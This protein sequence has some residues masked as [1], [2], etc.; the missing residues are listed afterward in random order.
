MARIKTDRFQRAVDKLMKEVEVAVEDAKGDFP[1][2]GEDDLFYEMAKAM[3]L[4]SEASEAVKNEVRR[5][6]GIGGF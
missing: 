5:C 4:Q 6:Y 1:D 3:L 2:V